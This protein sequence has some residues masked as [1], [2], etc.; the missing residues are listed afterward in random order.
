[1]EPGSVHLLH[2]HTL[3]LNKHQITSHCTL[4]TVH[5]SRARDQVKVVFA[6]KKRKAGLSTKQYSIIKGKTSFTNH[7]NLQIKKIICFSI[8][9]S[10]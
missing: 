9:S 5:R 10:F 2:W 6:C 1:M 3:L 7:K 8:F 4:Y